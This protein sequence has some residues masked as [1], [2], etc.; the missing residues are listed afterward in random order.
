MMLVDRITY[1]DRDTTVSVTVDGDHFIITVDTNQQILLTLPQ[2]I[3]LT[4]SLKRVVEG[5]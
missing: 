3:A 5:R 4:E 1:K 2:F